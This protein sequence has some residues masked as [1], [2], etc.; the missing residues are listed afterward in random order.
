LERVKRIVSGEEK[1]V[2]HDEV[3]ERLKALL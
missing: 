2:S 1:T 3:Y